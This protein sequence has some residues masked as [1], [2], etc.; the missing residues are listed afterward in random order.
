[1]K[2]KRE[3]DIEEETQEDVLLIVCYSKKIIH[4][5]A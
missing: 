3:K 4:W 2:A 5:L 1:M